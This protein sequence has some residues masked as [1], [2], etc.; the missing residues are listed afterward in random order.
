LYDRLKE[1]LPRILE[2][3]EQV[4]EPFKLRCFE[5]LFSHLLESAERPRPEEPSPTP[6]GGPT[7]FYLPSAVPAAPA[8]SPPP[9]PAKVRAYLRRHDITEVQLRRVVMIE[10]AEAHF[11]REPHDVPNAVG[12]IQWALLLA[13][14]NA[15]TGTSG[16][17]EVDPEAV[18][19]ICI[20]KGLYD[21]NNFAANFKRNAE[22]FR[23]EMV[24]QGESRP[25]SDEGERRLADII[26]GLAGPE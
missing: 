4:P 23:G 1:E 19:S 9:I 14:R 6:P 26:R 10:G 16:A 3:V 13:L 25:L 12:Q 15:L 24:S 8:G 17:L 5:L 7:E 22:L 20:E 2:I 18:R 11:I 21:R